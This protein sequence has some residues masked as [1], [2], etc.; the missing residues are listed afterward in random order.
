[1]KS[2]YTRH[3]N[4]WT[5]FQLVLV[6]LLVSA[7]ALSAGGRQ[8]TQGS[9]TGETS[10]SQ[11]SGTRIDIEEP[12]EDDT[13]TAD[14]SP[15]AVAIDRPAWIMVLHDNTEVMQEEVSQT[16]DNGYIPTGLEVSEDGTFTVLYT[17]SFGAVPE[18]WL[19]ES[20]SPD[21]V[22]T[23]LSQRLLQGWNPLGFSVLNKQLIVMYGSGGPEVKS[24]RIH[25]T[26]LDQEA[27]QQTVQEYQNNGFA[28]VDISIDPTDE[29]LWYLFV[30]Q[31]G[32]ATADSQL[33]LNA[34]P[35]GEETVAGISS[36]YSRG[37][38][39]PYGLATGDAISLVLFVGNATER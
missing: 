37:R 27:L 20:Y 8:E 21:E 30:Q 12:S 4:L 17:V 34:Y 11:D 32:R 10:G 29:E 6:L 38:G 18:R 7:T 5:T 33:F 14:A 16:I 35:A 31:E 22:N 1:M 19:I 15:Q 13:D 23:E 2:T 28:I 39:V 24:W 9:S 25:Q 3:S 36:D 26:A